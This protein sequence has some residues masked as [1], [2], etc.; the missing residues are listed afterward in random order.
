M[1]DQH[2]LRGNSH[3]ARP[4]HGQ[5]GPPDSAFVRQE[6]SP[7]V[8]RDGRQLRQRQSDTSVTEQRGSSKR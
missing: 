1:A 8:G 2:H 4:Q 6:K 7:D 5:Y 3:T